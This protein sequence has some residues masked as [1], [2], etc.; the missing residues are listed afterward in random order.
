LAHRADL[1]RIVEAAPEAAV[2]IDEAY[3][4]FR[5]ET[6]ITEIGRHP[7]LFVGRTFS[8][9]YGLAGLR[10]G[11]LAGPVE[12]IALIRRFCP[13]FNVNSAA[14]A[15]LE[16]AINDQDFARD[17]VTQMKQG[18][19]QIESLCAELG[20]HTWPSSTNF[21]LIRIGDRSAVFIEAMHSRGIVVRDSSANP[22][23]AGCVRITAAK[24]DQMNIV[25]RAI[26]ESWA[27]IR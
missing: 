24:R 17:Y 20:V 9:V 6:V 14:L 26:R 12:Q 3:F 15:C 2:L 11:V 7:N 8:K 25:L 19:S 22:G 23:C 4:E 18:C 21:V 5:G 27:A 1:L 10:I 13:P 16:A